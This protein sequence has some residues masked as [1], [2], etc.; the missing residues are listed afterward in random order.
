MFSDY[1]KRLTPEHAEV[2]KFWLPAIVAG[3]VAWLILLGVGQTPLIRG[4]GLSLVIVGVTA[5]L[6]R[7]G[8]APAF[9]GG[10]TL[11]VSP[12]FWSQTGGAEG[13]PATIVLALLVAVVVTLMTMWWLR[14][15]PYIGIG[16]GIVLFVG[17]FWSQIGTPNS[18]RLT[19]LVMGW[20]LF[21]IIDML[22]LTN[23][24]QDDVERRAPSILLGQRLKVNPTSGGYEAQV[25][26]WGGI[27][28]LLFIGILNDPLLMMMVPAAGVALALSHTRLGWWVWALLGVVSAIGLYGIWADYLALRGHFFVMDEWRNAERW[29]IVVNFVV[30]QFTIV[31]VGLGILGIARLS[32]WYA[33]LGTVTMVGYGAYTFFGLVYVGPRFEVLLLPLLVIQILWMTYA[34]FTLGEWLVKGYGHERVRWL[35][36]GLYGLAPMWLLWQLS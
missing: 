1:Y 32:R 34:V 29:L 21:L 15:H 3:V 30:E 24:R 19:S 20:L 36:Y 5:S 35:A 22:L 13:E 2:V 4:T 18:V 10:M 11:T 17:F 31:G 7:M 26:H 6:R 12:A 33:P 8:S 25:Y 14:A 27:L 28:F 16:A 9:V 23:P